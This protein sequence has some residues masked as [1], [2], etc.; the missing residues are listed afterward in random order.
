VDLRLPVPESWTVEA[1]GGKRVAVVPGFAGP[2]PD[3]LLVWGELTLLPDE[4]QRWIREILAADTVAGATTS[5]IRV[6]DG[7]TATGWPMR[8]V[9]AEI[10][11]GGKLVELRLGAFYAFLEH[12]GV[13]LVRA[14][15]RERY[16]AS[17]PAL[18]TLLVGASPDFTSEVTAVAQIWDL[19]GSAA[20][21]A[22]AVEASPPAP[23]P[24][25]ERAALEARLV[26]VDAA[27]AAAAGG[28]A[29]LQHLR[30]RALAELGRPAE[31]LAA[32]RRAI[33][34]DP[35]FAPAHHS[36]GLLLADLGCEADALAAWNAASAADPQHVDARFNAGQAHENRGELRQALDCWA[37]VR[38]L[39]PDDFEA[40][41]KV[42]QAQHALGL[43]DA[44]LATRAE[45]LDVWRRSPDPAIQAV[46]EFVFDRFRAGAAT[47]HASEPLAAADGPTRVLVQFATLDGAGRRLPL[48]VQLETS[49]F[50][51]E[52]GLPFVLAS[53]AGGTYRVV[54]TFAERPAYPALRALVAEMVVAALAARDQSTQ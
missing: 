34:I 31:A 12:A 36:I 37:E 23:R 25:G 43:W 44:A 40:A 50:G 35:A 28:D 18:R 20:T 11:A 45:L 42:L 4:Q 13:A 10:T 32:F 7:R 2:R 19:T 24:A 33:A 21:G 22:P 51:R 49:D 29:R 53:I 5:V 1:H 8:I 14:T 17:T 54:R 39:R 27:L 26:E 46:T 15:S 6:E 48:A 52:R 3:V 30:G 38:R 9:E 16:A 41:K 47:V